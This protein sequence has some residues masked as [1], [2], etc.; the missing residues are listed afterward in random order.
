[1]NVMNHAIFSEATARVDELHTM[2]EMLEKSGIPKPIRLDNL[3]LRTRHDSIRS[4]NAVLAFERKTSDQ[5]IIS[6]ITQKSSRVLAGRR[7]QDHHSGRDSTRSS[8]DD[9]ASG[10]LNIAKCLNVI[11]AHQRCGP[12]VTGDVFYA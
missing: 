9:A 4:R 11:L 10:L 7:I 3:P 8:T 12:V 2:P 6:Q 5:Q 1:M